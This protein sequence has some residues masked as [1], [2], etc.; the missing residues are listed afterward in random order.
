M[1]RFCP[2][3]RCSCLGGI[4]SVPENENKEA[5]MVVIS[6]KDTEDASGDSDEHLARYTKVHSCS[7]SSP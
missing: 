4:P 3:E 2:W 5:L 1:S 6:R 7:A